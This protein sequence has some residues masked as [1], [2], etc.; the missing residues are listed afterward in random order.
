M[1]MYDRIMQC[2]NGRHGNKAEESCSESEGS[3][4]DS[5]S[6]MSEKIDPCKYVT[7]ECQHILFFSCFQ[8]SLSLMFSLYCEFYYLAIFNTGLLLTSII[9]WR[10]PKLGLS[11]T[12]DI[13]MTL[14]NILMHL[15]HSFKINSMCFFVCICGAIFMFILYF[16]GKRFSYNSYSTLYHLLIH[17]TGTMSSLSIYYISKNKL[18]DRA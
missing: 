9:H 1:K 17:T 18:I 5:S 11:R 3:S 6:V 15:I 14:M 4:T 2:T 8:L 7:Y 10:N 16:A 12:V 13:T